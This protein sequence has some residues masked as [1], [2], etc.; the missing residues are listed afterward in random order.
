[1]EP[2]PQD[3]LTAEKASEFL[4]SKGGTVFLT[5]HEFE[6]AVQ[7]SDV[8]KKQIGASAGSAYKKSTQELVNLL[9]L[10]AIEGERYEEAVERGKKHL[11]S[12]TKPQ[13][14]KLEDKTS[15][16]LEELRT[17]HQEAIEKLELMQSEVGNF[18]EK[19]FKS[20]KLNLIKQ[21]R[22]GKKFKIPEGVDNKFLENHENMFYSEIE[23]KC[24]FLVE[25]G[26]TYLKHQGNTY[27]GDSMV[28]KLTEIIDSSGY[29]FEKKA[30]NGSYVELNGD[31]F[32]NLSQD[33]K[34]E[35]LKKKMSEKGITDPTSSG[36]WKIR[37]ELGDNIPDFV[38]KMF[39]SLK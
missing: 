27:S 33:K 35:L 3:E 37:K 24:E 18:K 15:P 17:K 10:P 26:K 28:S 19:E 21:A 22:G 29:E 32:L 11:M 6:E 25:D 5:G 1:M 39:P 31:K 36:A 16:E 7:N 23:S 38:L 2:N 34:S 14:V 8:F 12:I 4:K 13:E 30:T 9:G 20:E